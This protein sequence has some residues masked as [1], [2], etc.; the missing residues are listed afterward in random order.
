MA[1]GGAR[2]MGIRPTRPRID[3]GELKLSG[4]RT[5]LHERSPRV[6]SR[7]FGILY[8]RADSGDAGGSG[9]G[10]GTQKSLYP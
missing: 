5:H 8:R 3:I 4:T 2:S 7:C 9:G 6:E 10:S 1:G